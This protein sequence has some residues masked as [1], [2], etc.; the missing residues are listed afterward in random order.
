MKYTKGKRKAAAGVSHLQPSR[1]PLRLS[2]CLMETCDG[3]HVWDPP[4][5][6]FISFV[7][8]DSALTSRSKEKQ[9]SRSEAKRGSL[10]PRQIVKEEKGVITNIKIP[11]VEEHKG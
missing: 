1:F 3:V 10:V 8:E 6:L 5:V 11:I 4:V 9:E 7:S 2:F